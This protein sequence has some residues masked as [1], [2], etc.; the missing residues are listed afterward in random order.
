MTKRD[1]KQKTSDRTIL[2]GDN[3]QSLHLNTHAKSLE[4]LVEV[5]PLPEVGQME[6][7]FEY[8][9]DVVDPEWSPLAEF[10]VTLKF[11]LG[12]LESLFLW[13]TSEHVF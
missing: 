5:A 8:G 11:L 2:F 1:Q 6:V 12:E 9:Q 13:E 3:G 10:S 4:L 7:V